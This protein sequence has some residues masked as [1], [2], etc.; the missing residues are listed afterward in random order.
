MYGRTPARTRDASDLVNVVPPFHQTWAKPS[1][2]IEYPPSYARGVLYE[3]TNSG[4]TWA[5]DAFTGKLLWRRDIGAEIRA[6]PTVAGK[7]LY[8]GAYNGNVY[9]L[10]VGNGS[11]VWTRHIGG[12]IESPPAVAGGRL[13]LGDLNGHMRAL[14]AATGRPIWTSRP[15]AR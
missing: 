9:A 10:R 4:S 3:A 8:F 5:R 11:S 1:G 2:F 12:L 6:E 13:Y 15:P 7:I 14:D